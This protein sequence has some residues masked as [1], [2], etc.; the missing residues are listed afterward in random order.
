[1]D[2]IY[3]YGKIS[4]IAVDST[5]KLLVYLRLTCENLGAYISVHVIRCASYRASVLPACARLTGE[6]G[7]GQ[8]RALQRP[9][10]TVG[11]GWMVLPGC[12]LVMC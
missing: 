6:S 10:L 12:V 3:K 7:N 9:S 4:K 11:T 8:S 5:G 2:Y 1:M